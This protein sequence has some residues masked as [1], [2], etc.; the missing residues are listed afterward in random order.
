MRGQVICIYPYVPLNFRPPKFPGRGVDGEVGG[1]QEVGAGRLPD[2]TCVEFSFS[3]DCVSAS[4]YRFIAKG[5]FEERGASGAMRF[6][7]PEGIRSSTALVGVHPFFE[8][9]VEI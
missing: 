2:S 4:E 7:S 1:A 9:S 8:A 3:G 5:A 6:Q